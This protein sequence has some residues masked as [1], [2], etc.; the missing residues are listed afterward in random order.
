[1]NRR[2]PLLVAGLALVAAGLALPR[3]WYDALPWGAELPPQPIKGVTLLQAALVL[4]GLVLLWIAW[5]RVVWNPLPA[6]A[7]TGPA[8]SQDQA[9]P[10]ARRGWMLLAAVTALGLALRLIRLD[11]DLWLDE[12][13]PIRDYAQLP[14]L[15]VVAT[16]QRSNN[17][18]L[19]TLLMKLSLALFGER[20]WTVRI[21]AALFGA[22]TVPA[23]Y[24][25]A[26]QAVSR[27]AALAA[28]LLLAVSY[29]HVFFSQNA[30]GYAGYL[31]FAV[32]SAGFLA[33]A[34][35]EDRFGDW[36]LYVGCLFLGFA[37]QLLTAFVAAAHGLT[38][39][40]AVGA[41]HRR[42][43]PAAPLLA[44]LAAVY[45]VAGLVVF[46]LYA[47][48]I[49]QAYVVAQTTYSR[50]T[51]GFSGLSLEFLG[52]LAR[53]VA[54]G[55]GPGLLLGA[56]PF[57][58]LTAA[59]F[60]ALWRRHWTL[61]AALA[62][63][64]LVT[65][66][67]LLLQGYSFSPRFFLLAIPLATLC[68]AQGLWSLAALV[69]RRSAG[70]DPRL[71][72]RLAAALALLLALG[73]AAALP[74]YYRTPKQDYRGSIRYIEDQRRAGDLVVVFGVA[75]WGYRYY[76]GR[77]GVAD[78]AVYRYTRS[79][80][81]VDSVIAERGGGTVWFVTTLARDM[82]L[83]QP[84]LAERLRSAEWTLARRFEGTVGDGA[85][86]VWRRG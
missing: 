63:P 84:R 77:L 24:W 58:A 23:L 86:L 47:A 2:F 18:L 65:A 30:R 38:G 3:G 4:E 7:L 57:L 69:A 14:V 15:E 17:H 62:L 80:A 66:A 21:W 25:A 41:V 68:A 43:G 44:R 60:V 51:S 27:G 49:P 71:A 36:A 20:E 8:P 82:R 26:R 83:R 74:S 32:L 59:G 56:V 79:E 22:A 19:Q 54:A 45:A 33:R 11:A 72:P 70:G 6:S 53:G 31:L 29:H 46:H 42:G 76:T 48:V 34:L 81:G 64:E 37:S 75:E 10:E 39:L 85:V 28:A 78:D 40:L 5:R 35:R 52:E 1:V 9:G 61:A 73:S 12:I 13:T 67:F 55:F 50:A 16:Y